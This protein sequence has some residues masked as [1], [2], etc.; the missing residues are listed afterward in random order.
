MSDNKWAEARLWNL[1][2]GVEKLKI[3]NEIDESI[4]EYAYMLDELYTQHFQEHEL[5]SEVELNAQLVTAFLRGI[6]KDKENNAILS[7][8]LSLLLRDGINMMTKIRE[9][10]EKSKNSAMGHLH[11]GSLYELRKSTPQL[12]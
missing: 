11:R 10:M 4:K 7:R 2:A 8:G 1:K 9:D 6:E 12:R 3:S 5:F